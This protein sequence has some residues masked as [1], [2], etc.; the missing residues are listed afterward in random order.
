[1]S[2]SMTIPT[3]DFATVLSFVAKLGS[4]A[5]PGALPSRAMFAGRVN[6]VFVI[7]NDA[8][9]QALSRRWSSGCATTYGPLETQAV[10]PARGRSLALAHAGRPPCGPLFRIACAWLSR[11]VRRAPAAHGRS[12]WY[13]PKQ[14]LKTGR[15]P[16]WP[17]APASLF[18]A[19]NHLSARPR[20]A[21]IHGV[22]RPA[23]RRAPW[24]STISHFACWR[25]NRACLFRMPAARADRSRPCP[26]SPPFPVPD[27]RTRGNASPRWRPAAVRSDPVSPARPAG[28]GI[29]PDRRLVQ[30]RALRLVRPVSAP[31]WPMRTL[32]Y[33]N[34]RT[35]GHRPARAPGR[36]GLDALL[37]HPPRGIRPC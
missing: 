19:K 11:P 26:R 24:S 12:G 22:G 10:G 23:A 5:G 2:G 13:M 25:G 28:D 27:R 17:I 3:L 34:V 9:E 6:R 35:G 29:H 32:I 31:G 15:G 14:A 8:E 20:P 18:D 4:V 33:R 7:V 30:R 1:M 36:G 16:A 21:V 37:R